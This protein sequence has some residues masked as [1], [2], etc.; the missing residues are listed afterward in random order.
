MTGLAARE[1][2]SAVILAAGM[3]SRLAG[4]HSDSPKGFLVMDEKAIVEE[5]VDKL[6]AAGIERIVIVTGHLS[7]YYEKLAA[8]RMSRMARPSRTGMRM[9]RGNCLI[10]TVHNPDY[11]K[12]GS[13]YSLYCARHRLDSD[14]L[15]LESD[16]VYEKRALDV[17]MKGP[18]VDAVLMSGPT[19][20][21]DEV[22]IEARDGLLRQMSKNPGELQA[23][24]G[25]LVGICRIST[26]LYKQMCDSAERAFEDTLHVA[27]ETDSLVG[28]AAERPI[29]CPLVSDLLWGEIDDEAHLNRVREQVY[30]AIERRD[31]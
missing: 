18:E 24:S 14:F 7:E 9:G 20:A 22:Y 6:A 17:L 5:S 10:E 31:G 16:L 12:S 19:Q 30:P 8:S 21:G 26:G 2:R 13:M 28:A 1:P 15:L 23:I 4:Q 25:E 29:H 27:Y 11:A 3:G